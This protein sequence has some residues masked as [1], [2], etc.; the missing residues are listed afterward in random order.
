[1]AAPRCCRQPPGSAPGF[2]ALLGSVVGELFEM[3]GDVSRLIGCPVS[4][5]A[6]LVGSLVDV[7]GGTTAT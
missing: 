2:A 3:L 5:P 4:Q 1:M 7:R 6:E